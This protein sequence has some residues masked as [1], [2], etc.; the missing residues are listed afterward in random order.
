M[1]P[2]QGSVGVPPPTRTPSATERA[3]PVAARLRAGRAFRFPDSPGGTTDC[4]PGREPWEN[5]A[6]LPTSSPR[7]ASERRPGHGAAN[8]GSGNQGMRR[9]TTVRGA[10][11]SGG[12]PVP[13][14]GLIPISNLPPFLTCRS[15]AAES[16]RPEICRLV[17]PKTSVPSVRDEAAGYPFPTFVPAAMIAEPPRRPSIACMGS[18]DIDIITTRSAAPPCSFPWPSS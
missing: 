13:S 2:R 5:R 12:W 11:E 3:V 8:R 4:S 15:P 10:G 16:T 14:I 18:P 9:R 6:S 1:P 17:A 7:G